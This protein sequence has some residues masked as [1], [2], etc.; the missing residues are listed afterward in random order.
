MLGS[1]ASS[2]PSWLAS[3][4]SASCSNRL[5][6]AGTGG[7]ADVLDGGER[8]DGFRPSSWC[9]RGRAAAAVCEF[10]TKYTSVPSSSCSP[11]LC[12]PGAAKF[13][14]VKKSRGWPDCSSSRIRRRSGRAC[15]GTYRWSAEYQDA[16]ARA[17]QLFAI[18]IQGETPCWARTDA[19]LVM[20][21]R[22]DSMTT[23]AH[24][25]VELQFRG[26]S[27]GYAVALQPFIGDEECVIISNQEA[28]PTAEAQLDPANFPAVEHDLAVQGYPPAMLDQTI[29]L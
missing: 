4:E 3:I 10:L 26:E 14:M 23:G 7:A 22:L 13:T 9:L 15:S 20:R 29:E 12:I 17:S 6:P 27:A 28:I 2:L 25:K 19:A 21:R 5:L 18:G 24:E 16:V 1:W 8:V 11:R